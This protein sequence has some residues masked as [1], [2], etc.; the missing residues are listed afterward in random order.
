MNDTWPDDVEVTLYG[1]KAVVADLDA[2][3]TNFEP[4]S[5]CFENLILDHIVSTTL[6][7]NISSRDV[8]DNYD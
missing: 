5:L 2:Q 3:L 8:F 1:A 4:L 6:L 7:P